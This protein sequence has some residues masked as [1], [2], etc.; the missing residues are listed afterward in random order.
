MTRERSTGKKRSGTKRNQGG[1]RGNEEEKPVPGA[2]E[3]KLPPKLSTDARFP[4][5]KGEI[6]AMEG[7]K[8]TPQMVF[9][10]EKEETVNNESGVWK[11]N[12]STDVAS[13]GD[14]GGI[15]RRD[16]KGVKEK[17]PAAKTHNND[18]RAKRHQ[19]EEV[20]N[21]KAGKKRKQSP[22]EDEGQ[23]RGAKPLG[24]RHMEK[25][26]AEIQ[27]LPKGDN[28]DGKEK[29]K[30]GKRIRRSKLKKDRLITRAAQRNM[31]GSALKDEFPVL[32]DGSKPKVLI[33]ACQYIMDKQGPSSS[34]IHELMQL[35]P[36]ACYIHRTNVCLDEVVEYA[37]ER[38]FTSLIVALSDGLKII[39]LPD[40]PLAHLELSEF[41]PRKDIKNH[42]EP[43]SRE[44]ELVFNNFEAHLGYRLQRLISSLF[45]QADFNKRQVF[46]FE[47]K[48][49]HILFR[50][51]R[52]LYEM[53]EELR[54]GNTGTFPGVK[55]KASDVT[56]HL[57][58]SELAVDFRNVIEARWLHCTM[59][60]SLAVNLNCSL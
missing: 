28:V 56:C 60:T 9:M 17:K 21:A 13:P 12:Q 8:P 34:F 55:L 26:E 2:K 35:I 24:T 19:A 5:D 58:V 51:H 47:L 23:S 30:K 25:S 53:K 3:E 43:I 18:S 10:A 31:F 33:T 20:V 50:N 45:P 11:R 44:P 59:T 57:L 38:K 42:G 41:T 37:N 48:Q 32:K 39:N 52:Y 36:D 6:R 22:E 1:S 49:Q 46:T 54:D 15:T 14:S 27:V 4:G 40:G 7:K 16:G 29:K